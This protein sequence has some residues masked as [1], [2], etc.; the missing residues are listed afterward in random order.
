[1]HLVA[2]PPPS[3]RTRNN[4]HPFIDANHVDDQGISLPMGRRV[5]I[6]SGIRIFGMGASI[7]VYQTNVQ[8]VFKHLPQLPSRERN[9]LHGG[10][11]TDLLQC[12]AWNA[13]LITLSIRGRPRVLCGYARL[14]GNLFLRRHLGIE[15][16][17]GRFF[18]R[19]SKLQHSSGRVWRP[20]SA[21][22]RMS[23]RRARRGSARRQ[24]LH[25]VETPDDRHRRFSPR[26]R[27]MSVLL[28]KRRHGNDAQS[29]EYDSSARKA[30]AEPSLRVS[31]L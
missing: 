3:A 27:G 15:L 2:R 6:E 18:Q 22:V 28:S 10:V 31:H 1:M 4:P 12:R 5:A 30:I 19:V 25:L 8:R 9:Q 13:R 11:L 7:S 29:R 14:E 26:L 17:D 20:T 21:Q 24:Y 16:P 23:V